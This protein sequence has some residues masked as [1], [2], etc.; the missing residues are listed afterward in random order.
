MV[1]GLSEPRVGVTPDPWKAQLQE[2]RA[3]WRRRHPKAQV[4]TKFGWLWFN[5][6]FGRGLQETETGATGRRELLRHFFDG[7]AC[8][9]RALLPKFSPRARSVDASLVLL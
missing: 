7:P 5:S 6:V 9:T 8:G 3:E 1:R 4:M 2:A